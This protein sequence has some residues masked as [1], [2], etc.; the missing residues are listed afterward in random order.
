[1]DV[2][3]D[4]SDKILATFR[5][6]RIKWEQFKSKTGDVGSTASAMLLD[7]INWYLAGNELPK[8]GETYPY[9]ASNLDNIENCLDKSIQNYIDLKLD[10]FATSYR[11]TLQG[12][13]ERLERAEV[14]LGE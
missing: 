14:A 8:R 3:L 4:M 9:P 6:D 12:L 13:Y 1:M 2:N 5:I 10:S 7:F 11:A